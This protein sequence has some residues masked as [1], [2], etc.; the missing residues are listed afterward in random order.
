MLD[1]MTKDT[2][3]PRE[4]EVFELTLPDGRALRVTLIAV[5][6][7]GLKGLAQREQFSLHF[8]G[9]VTPALDQRIYR[10]VHPEL[11]TLEL[12]LVPIGRDADA[13]IYEA[14]FA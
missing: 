14:A 9:P 1:R 11:G 8:K 2:F 12:F 7:T 4:G 6:G 5:L 3:A 10:L 13:M